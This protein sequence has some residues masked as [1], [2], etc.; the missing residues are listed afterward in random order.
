MVESQSSLP[1]YRARSS[2]LPQLHQWSVISVGS[3]YRIGTISVDHPKSQH[4]LVERHGACQVSHLQADLPQTGGRRQTEASGWLAIATGLRGFG[5]FGA[6]EDVPC[7][8][9]HM[10]PSSLQNAGAAGRLHTTIG[11][12]QL[13]SNHFRKALDPEPNRLEV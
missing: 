10:S 6:A 2:L 4:I 12:G 7:G 13:T 1:W 5:T 8:S 3:Q 11:G 9:A